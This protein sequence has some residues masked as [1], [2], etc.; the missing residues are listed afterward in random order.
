MSN[1][2]FMEQLKLIVQ[3]A[4][5]E[6][7]EMLTK[8]LTSLDFVNSVELVE[9]KP[10]TSDDEQNFFSLAGLWENRDITTESIRQQAWMEDIQ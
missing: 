2:T 10:T 3:V 1:Y 6:K 8:I 9:N 5:K 4:D 7:A